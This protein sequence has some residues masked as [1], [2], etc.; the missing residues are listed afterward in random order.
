VANINIMF[1]NNIML[2]AEPRLIIFTSQIIIHC[3]EFFYK[4]CLPYNTLNSNTLT[5]Q[6]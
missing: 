6:T 2:I 4:V 1:E 5:S 3:K